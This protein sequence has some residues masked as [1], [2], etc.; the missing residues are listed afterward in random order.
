MLLKHSILVKVFGFVAVLLVTKAAIHQFELDLVTIGPL[1][2][3]FV[4]GGVIFIIAIILACTLSDYKV[5]K[6]PLELAASILILYKDVR[7]ASIDNE[8]INTMRDRIRLLS[9]INYNF[10]SKVW[11]QTDVNLAMDEIDEDIVSLAQKGARPQF[12]VRLRN[13]LANIDRISNCIETIKETTFIRAAFSV[14]N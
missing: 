11:K 10:K 3:A 4:G 7:I 5:K 12:I 9:T 2:T 1:V 6:I 8:R 13:E 14:A